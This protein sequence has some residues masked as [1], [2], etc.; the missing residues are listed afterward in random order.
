MQQNQIFFS[1]KRKVNCNFFRRLISFI[2]IYISIITSACTPHYTISRSDNA[3]TACAEKD[4]F[5]ILSVR[6][7]EN[8]LYDLLNSKSGIIKS[9]INN[10]TKYEVQILYTQINRNKCNVP[11]FKE[12]SFRA[13]ASQY[14]NPASLV[15]LPIVCLSFQ[16]LNELAIIGLDKNTCLKIGSQHNCQTTASRDFTATEGCPTIAQYAKKMLLVSDNDAYNRL[17]E[18]L[19]QEYINKTLWNMGYKNARIIRRFKDCNDDDNRYTNP[20]TFFN[21][22][23]EVIYFQ[24]LQVP[25]DTYKNP[26]IKVKKGNGYID[27]T[28]KYRN[29]PF[30]YSFSNNLSLQDI[31]NMLLSIIFPET[32]AQGNRFSLTENDYTFLYRYL[33]QLPGES[34]IVEY[35]N[36][37]RY[38]DNYKKYLLFGDIGNGTISKS[39]LRIFNIVGRSDGYLSDCAYIVDFENKIEFFLASVIY[40]NEDQILKDNRYEYDSIG[41]PFLA[42]L[43]RTIYEYEKIR[44]RD[45]PPDL[46][47]FKV[48]SK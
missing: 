34:G 25:T 22:D 13:D 4:S 40:V 10:S 38:P 31:H 8:A 2:F 21:Q 18:F 28:G 35:N 26:L 43:G 16:K 19:G 44:K 6:E 3:S 20:F 14:F 47:K 7:P 46:N 37:K 32:C 11:S 36:S 48:F 9:V 24:P 1:Q 29:K 45:Y 5:Q 17:Y 23:G 39:S 33:S 42:E 12:F 27:N 41:L 15:K 30:D